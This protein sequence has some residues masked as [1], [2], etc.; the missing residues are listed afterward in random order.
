MAFLVVDKHSRCVSGL[1]PL[2]LSHI[3]LVNTDR[4]YGFGWCAMMRV[5]R[6]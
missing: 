6:G 4:N 1:H 5:P 2:V 3:P